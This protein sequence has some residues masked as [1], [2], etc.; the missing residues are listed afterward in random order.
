MLKG[1]G[2]ALK[3][4]LLGKS[5]CEYMAQFT[6]SQDYWNRIIAAQV[7][8]SL[9]PSGSL[10]TLRESMPTKE[11]NDDQTLWQPQINGCMKSS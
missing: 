11:N 2:R 9:C 3:R 4:V 8:V 1:I 7:A 10:P 5:T 6:G